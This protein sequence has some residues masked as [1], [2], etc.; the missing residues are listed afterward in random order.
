MSTRESFLVRIWL[1]NASEPAQI[2]GEV[3]HV[4]TGHRRRFCGSQELVE[5][6]EAWT[7]AARE[8]ADDS[9]S[10]FPPVEPSEGAAWSA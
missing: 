7:R 10:R 2:R 4:R 1:E 8:C 6:L 5:I 3:E 9:N